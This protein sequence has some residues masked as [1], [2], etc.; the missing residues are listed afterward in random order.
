MSDYDKEVEATRA[1]NQPI[2]DAFQ[3]WLTEAGLADKTIRGHVENIDF[4]TEYLV[5]YDEPL[6]RLDEADAGDVVTFL[7]SW[8]PRKAMWASESSIKANIASFKKF[9][10]WLGETGR[11]S[12]ETTGEVLTML[13]EERDEFLRAVEEYEKFLDE[14][15]DDSFTVM[16]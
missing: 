1:Y 2:L 16:S 9:F 3:A 5:Y 10:Q 6:K 13:K 4:F 14:W 11:T 8:F 12:P 7:T 15:D